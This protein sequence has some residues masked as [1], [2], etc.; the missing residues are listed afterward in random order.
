[1]KKNNSVSDTKTFYSPFAIIIYFIIFSIVGLYLI[2]QLRI[3]FLPHEAPKTLQVSFT[4]PDAS[5]ENVELH[6]TSV[7]ENVISTIDGI[8][9]ISSESVQSAGNITVEFEDNKD[10]DFGRF[11]ITTLIKSVYRK[12]PPEVTYPVVT[13]PS[14]EKNAIIIY[15]LNSEYDDETTYNYAVE[16]IKP[17]LAQTQG[18]ENITVSG[19]NPKVWHVI[20]NESLMQIYNLSA[21]DLSNK[22]NDFVQKYDLGL[23]KV[24]ISDSIN[25]R[26]KATVISN[27]ISLKNIPITKLKDKILYLGD[28]AKIEYSVD[29]QRNFSRI[30]GLN[31]V[32]IAVYQDKNENIISLTKKINDKIKTLKLPPKF[33]LKKT[34]NAADFVTDEL[35][36]ILVRTLISL[37]LILLLLYAVSRRIEIIIIAAVSLIVTILTSAVFYNFFHFDINIYS[38][39]GISMSAGMIV[40]NIIM[41]SEHLRNRNNKTIFRPLFASTTATISTLSLI[42]FINENELKIL[43]QFGTAIVINLA[44]SLPVALFLI[45]ALFTKFNITGNKKK[46]NFNRLRLISK[47]KSIYRHVI[48]FMLKHKAVSVIF[49]VL[50]FG[51]PVHKLPNKIDS[52]NITAQIYNKTFGSRWYKLN[53]KSTVNT[54]LGGSLHQFT[55]K[56]FENSSIKE[57]EKTRLSIKANLPEDMKIEHLNEV[58]T[59]MEVFLKQFKEIDFFC[60]EINEYNQNSI[61]VFFKKEYETSNF[62]A[63]LKNEII[64]KAL[65]YDNIEWKID[66]AGNGFSN[67]LYAPV[68]SAVIFITGYNYEELMRHSDKLTKKLKQDPDVSG[69]TVSGN[70]YKFFAVE[71]Y[72]YQIEF[73]EENITDDDISKLLIINSLINK[74]EISQNITFGEKTEKLIIKS[75]KSESYNISAFENQ[76]IKYDSVQ[77][78]FPEY[79]AIGKQVCPKSIYKENQEFRIIIGFNYVTMGGALTR[80]VNTLVDE[81]NAELPFGYKS[82][83]ELDSGFKSNKSKKILFILA[84]VLIVF[85]ICAI[86]FESF[87]QSLIVISLIPISYIGAFFTFSW[88]NINFDQ[89]GYA[90]FFLL[91]GITVN[92]AIYLINDFNTIIKYRNISHSE[93]YLNAFNYK[94]NPILLTVISTSLGL[95]PFVFS[96]E[97]NVFWRAFSVGTIGGLIFSMFAVLIYLPVLMLPKQKTGK[98]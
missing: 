75:D 66:G 14:E 49:I 12:L 41:V 60:T 5:S 95:L 9:N 93:A 46:P 29:K 85:I 97:N 17:L 86:L 77:F 21:S 71:K 57:P 37:C 35:N 8:K 19:C 22:I 40:D 62:P 48:K 2:P 38:L 76:V 67:S 34:H 94:I 74:T 63:F 33:H 30:N 10:I 53:L 43:S 13:N 58:F 44:V 79:L 15:T 42:F 64:K 31:S 73:K 24:G 51:L 68:K 61:S 45:P 27:I 28:L 81:T 72:N 4:F 1:M 25:Y 91:T 90:S 70:I 32:S 20:F 88:F 82:F 80:Y 84:A 50:L 6:V 78:K 83:T 54:F 87:K 47:I 69:I 23:L 89:G 16:K 98:S 18:V 59:R 52:K 92:S 65:K 26:I 7:L 36:L 3:K 55:K 56:I 96:H 11:E 39:A